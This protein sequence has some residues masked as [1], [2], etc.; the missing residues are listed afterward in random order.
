MD[1]LV[2]DVEKKPNPRSGRE[3][4]VMTDKAVPV[5]M[6]DFGVFKA[7]RTWRCRADG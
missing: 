1:I 2:G 7:T 4:L 3:M 6:K 5:R